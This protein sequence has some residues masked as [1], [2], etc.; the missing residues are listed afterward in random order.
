M[1]SL[2]RQN[3]NVWRSL[4]DLAAREGQQ[5]GDA[6]L[7]GP[8]FAD[9]A[10][11]P[12]DGPTRRTFLQLMAASAG[13]AGLAGCH[14][15]KENILP[16]ARRPPEVT[17]GVP[18]LFATAMDIAGAGQG[19]V[20]T[21]FDGRPI[22]V[23]GNPLHPINRGGT[24]IFAQ[25]SVLGLYDADR[26]KNP[27]QAD[28]STPR[29]GFFDRNWNQFDEFATAHF[30]Q[31]R[32]RKGLG[33][34]VLSEASSSP[35]LAAMRA[36]LLGDCPLARWYD[37]D[38]V[39]QENDRA[40][41]ALAFGR[42]IRT[43]YALDKAQV[44]VSLDSNFVMMQPACLKYARDFISAHT[45]TA[46]N[47]WT[48]SRLYVVEPCYTN[49]GALADH[50][51]AAP[52]GLIGP[53]A[54]QLA[55]ALVELGP[56]VLNVPDDMAQV[57]RGKA[58]PTDEATTA[59]VRMV[60][61]DLL[62][63]QGQSAIM[64]GDGQPPEVHALGH[65]LN[66]AL[67][68]VG[69][70]VWY[71]AESQPE[72]S[73]GPEGLAALTRQINQG[74]VDTLLILGG[75]PVYTAPADADFSAALAK[76]PT[77][78][79]LGL[80]WDET[81]RL[82]TWHLPRAHYLETWGD[83][84][85]YDGT[86]S[87]AQPLIAPLYDGRSAIEVL[88]QLCETPA[89]SGYQIVRRTVRQL[90]EG[91]LDDA[92]FEDF[93]RKLLND[94]VW[95]DTQLK[96]VRPPLQLPAIQE[97]LARMAPVRPLSAQNL[98]LVLRPDPTIFDGR[99]AN[100]SWL[101]ETPDTMS[102]VT[103]DN[104]VWLAPATAAALGVTQEQI[105]ELR[106]GDLPP[107]EAPVYVMPGQAPWSAMVYLGYGRTAVGRV[108]DHVGFNA[109]P[110]RTSRA[111]DFAQG[112]RIVPTGRRYVFAMTQHHSHTDRIGRIG[113]EERLEEIATETT[114]T[115][116]QRDPQFAKQRVYHPPQSQ[117]W[118]QHIYPG[119]RWGMSI[120]MQKCIGCNACVVACQAENNVPVV[121]KEQVIRRRQMQWLRID[122]YFRGESANPRVTFQPMFCVHCENAPCE[123]VCP[124]A[125]TLHDADGLNLMVYNRCVGTRYCSNNCPYKV[126]HFNFY[127]WN[128]NV[129]ALEAMVKNPDVT[130]RSRGV[131]EKCTYC[132]QRIERAKIAAR[133]EQRPILTDEFT[134]ACAQACPTGA[135]VFGNLEDEKAAVTRLQGNS[136]S[137][138]VLVDLNTRPRSLHMMRVRNPGK[139]TE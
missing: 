123:S 130:V 76:V 68:N 86:F 3:K 2:E 74:Q 131:M 103:W 59:F 89:A 42:P 75:N 65:L 32:Q 138:A 101:Q 56:G 30:T 134:T 94:G 125:A 17:P 128:R 63:H 35:S 52:A 122:R 24:D 64:V 11:S 82:C 55:I 69:T 71:S 22:K 40:G 37:Y 109:Y 87:V 81:G 72:R 114:L 127:H 44:V 139:M 33:L 25:G 97:G 117:L 119:Y 135:I 84:R 7:A 21:S 38:P 79:H 88:S 29:G 18:L 111:M 121:G 129:S 16:Y 28:R 113:T 126:R 8:E 92:A 107:V 66:Y 36:R 49:T 100:N 31:L 96:P 12:P 136:R 19:L 6:A 104:S 73:A 58:G 5:P 80:Y 85:A 23:D 13:L 115:E 120:D 46:D 77:S 61:K 108:G 51:L 20:V 48:M 27:V 15:P 14:L 4:E 98:E 93:W 106:L 10:S 90:H 112:L 102:K 26:S 67:G 133:N 110:L 95:P 50:R 60:A 62:A 9:G 137:Y 124:V 105:V 47:R 54:C 91:P 83:V 39:V 1:S 43:H 99:F 78:I 57:L 70:T 34:R 116:W 41:A 132:I 118:P 45:P 53:I